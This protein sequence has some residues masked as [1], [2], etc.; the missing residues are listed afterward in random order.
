MNVSYINDQYGNPSAVVLP[1]AE[2]KKINE[3]FDILSD[4]IKQEFYSELS[5]AISEVN[6]VLNGKSETRDAIE[7]LNE[8]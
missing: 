7:F 1:I 8:L 2:W 3:T 4:N 6:L 5:E